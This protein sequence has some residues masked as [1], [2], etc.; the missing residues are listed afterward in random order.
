[1]FIL[2]SD[3]IFSFFLLFQML[4]LVG[5]SSFLAGKQRN[6]IISAQKA[7]HYCPNLADGYAVLC[8][9]LMTNEMEHRVPVSKINAML[10]LI[11]NMDAHYNVKSWA[12]GAYL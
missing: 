6:A 1:M 4:G 10:A 2:F 8:V 9:S 12:K 11:Q 7:I 3:K 5:L